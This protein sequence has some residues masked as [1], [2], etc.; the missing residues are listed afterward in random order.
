MRP[1]AVLYRTP[2]GDELLLGHGEEITHNQRNALQAVDGK[3]SADRLK[4]KAFW[5]SD[6]VKTLEEL[7]AM[8][9]I[10]DRPLAGGAAP[11]AARS[12]ESAGRQLKAQLAL[13]AEE[14]LGDNAGSIVQKIDETDGS[15]GALEQ[16]LVSCKKIIKLTISED[17]A[18]KFL[19]RG[20]KIIGK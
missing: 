2:K 15:P 6:I 11:G 3:L 19:Q 7:E 8:G 10:T 16:A 17:L 4:E 1:D 13:L 9:L 14:M 20:R 5:V 12:P 18:E